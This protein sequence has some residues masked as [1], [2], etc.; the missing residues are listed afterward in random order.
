MKMRNKLVVSGLAV[1]LGLV[2]AAKGWAQEVCS[3][4]VTGGTYSSTLYAGQNIDAGTVTATVTGTNLEV[5]YTTMDGW[6][7]TEAH[8]W[9]G[10][11][12]SDM[13]QSRKGNPIPGQFPYKSPDITGQ[14]SYT[15]Q[16]PLGE[17]GLAFKC[18]G[19]DAM[20]YLASHAALRKDVGGGSYQTETGWSDGARIVA[21]GNWATYSTITLTCDC[22]GG[23]AGLEC[24]T[25]FA[26]NQSNSGYEGV[27]DDATAACFLNLN[28]MDVNGID[29]VDFNRWGWTIGPLSAGLYTFDLWAAAG[30]CDLTPGVKVGTLGVDYDGSTATITY[31]TEGPYTLGET[32]A[33]AGIEP[34]PIK[35]G[36]YT[37]APGQYTSV[38]GGLDS[39]STT[40]DT[41]T[42]S[43]LS[44]NIYVVAHANACGFPAQ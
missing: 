8:L 24:E 17:T 21:K 7:L 5:T 30:Q 37:V 31:T 32:Q 36:A 6:E 27:Y 12:I 41:H 3:A 26:N 38:H 39:S 19:D 18:P 20:Y 11:N 43:N 22:N 4:M 28:F 42:I 33:Y 44:G 14:T 25:A 29:Q 13:P 35:N 10:S 40:S 16:V 1:L 15:F 2:V 34:L 9:V 23:G